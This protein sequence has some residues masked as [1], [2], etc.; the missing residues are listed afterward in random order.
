MLKLARQNVM[1][2]R[3]QEGHKGIYVLALKNALQVHEVPRFA[4]LPTLPARDM[5]QI[6]KERLLRKWSIPVWQSLLILMTPPS[7]KKYG[8][9]KYATYLGFQNSLCMH[10]LP[11]GKMTSS[12]FVSPPRF[13]TTCTAGRFVSGSWRRTRI[14]RFLSGTAYVESQDL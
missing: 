6:A 10:L 1:S 9:C 8:M 2:V 11:T 13:G 14:A 4:K 7:G 5:E 3:E 12:M